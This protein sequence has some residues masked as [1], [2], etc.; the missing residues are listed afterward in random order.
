[1]PTSMG[2]QDAVLQPGARLPAMAPT[3]T[4]CLPARLLRCSGPG[5]RAEFSLLRQKMRGSI[6]G[7][8][9][10]ADF[11][12]ALCGVA[13]LILALGGCTSNATVAKQVRFPS[14]PPRHLRP[15][16]DGRQPLASPALAASAVGVRKF[17]HR[18]VFGHS[19]QG[20]AL[21]AFRAGPLT[22]SRRI[23]VVGVIHGNETA[24]RAMAQDLLLTTPPATTEVVVVPD[25]NPDG[26]ARGTRQ[27]AAGVD[28]NRNFPF[29][30]Q[31]LGRR[32]D[33]QYSGTGPLSEPESRSMAALIR[34]LRPTVSVWFHQPVGIV[35]ESGGSL[36]VEIRF[37]KIL[38]VP[39]RQMPRYPGSVV[40]WENLSYPATTAFVVELPRHPSVSFRTRVLRALRDLER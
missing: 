40:S 33:Q 4:T 32:G 16:T 17:I 2:W 3:K 35:D 15:R 18:S 13:T 11:S 29:R 24:G 34:T 6:A 19:V 7:T 5:L 20:R 26:V 23:L 31:S 9:R 10:I 25:L 27:N 37:A 12:R 39:L 36:A 8:M 38:G 14:T 1:M 30:W 28:L 22:A 21:V